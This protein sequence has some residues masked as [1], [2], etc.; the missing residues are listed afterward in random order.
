MLANSACVGEVEEGVV[1]E[2]EGEGAGAGAGACWAVKLVPCGY[3]DECG[4][5]AFKW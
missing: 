2:G 1:G 3:F 5:L 4:H